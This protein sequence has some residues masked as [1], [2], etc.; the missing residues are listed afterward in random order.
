MEWETSAIYMSCFLG[1]PELDKPL[2]YS[3]CLVSLTGMHCLLLTTEKQ[4]SWKTRCVIIVIFYTFNCINMSQPGIIVNQIYLFMYNSDH[5]N[6]QLID[7]HSG[8]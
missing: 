1:A 6:Y 3:V 7:S 2:S 5:L 4:M 8:I